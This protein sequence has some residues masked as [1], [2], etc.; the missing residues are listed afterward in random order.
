MLERDE[1][2]GALAGEPELRPLVAER[3]A[4]LARG[5]AEGPRPYLGEPPP[6][7]D[8]HAA[9]DKFYGAAGT[10]LEGAGASPG[11]AEGRARVVRSLDDFGR[12][13]PGDV[14]VAVTTTPAW[15][16]LFPV[17]AALV[18]ETGGVLSHAAVVAREYGIPAV[19]G[20]EGATTAIADGARVV[21][22]G[23]SGRI[24]PA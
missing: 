6:G 8:R 18:T 1:L 3:R 22:D 16:P 10:A 2:R 15:T 24:R 5:L 13:E 12:V 17:L 7:R 9:L 21:V 23:T 20:A 14:L 11:I 4:E 19:V